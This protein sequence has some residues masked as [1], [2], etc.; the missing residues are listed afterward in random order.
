MINTNRIIAEVS[1]L[2][3]ND[4]LR[5]YNHD[6]DL[7]LKKYFPELIEQQ[8]RLSYKAYLELWWK[9]FNDLISYLMASIKDSCKP[10]DRSKKIYFLQILHKT[11]YLIPSINVYVAEHISDLEKK[12]EIDGALN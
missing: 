8:K 2:K 6:N 1:M 4:W 12:L 7:L 11:Q 10:K 5:L 3:Y 9:R